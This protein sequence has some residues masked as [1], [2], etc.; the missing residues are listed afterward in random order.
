MENKLE[1]MGGLEEIEEIKKDI[2]RPYTGSKSSYIM[3]YFLAILLIVATII[4][5]LF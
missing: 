1:N 5:I 3:G 2:T 4:H